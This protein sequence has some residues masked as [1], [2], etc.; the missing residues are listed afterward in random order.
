MLLFLAKSEERSFF[1]SKNKIM[2][3]EIRRLTFS[4]LMIAMSVVIGIICKNYFTY[5][6]Y[7]RFTLENLPI[8]LA[9]YLLGPVYG[10]GV[11]F[12]ADAISCLMSTNPAL[13]PIISLGAVTV[14]VLAGVMPIIFKKRSTLV[15]S[16]SVISAHLAGQ[17][18]IKSIA[19]MI[20]FDM[21]RIGILVGL[22]I[23]AIAGCIE[24]FTIRM[25]LKNKA[26][27]GLFE[28]VV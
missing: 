8:I 9:A 4:A 24:F 20:Y 26:L 15:L 27:K 28:G 3:K 1:M 10:A 23:S 25:I 2:K 17:V 5:L 7:Y 21:P 19:K 11:A 18:I 22:A 12:C 14:G 6:I 16:L 13:N